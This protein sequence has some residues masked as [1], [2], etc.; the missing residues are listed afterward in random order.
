MV[1]SHTRRVASLCLI[2]VPSC[3]LLL[4]ALGGR[5]GDPWQL[6]D[7]Q[8]RPR[9]RV[10][11]GADGAFEFVFLDAQGAKKL[12][13]GTAGDG[14]PLVK[15]SNGTTSLRIAPE[16]PR[17]ELA[18]TIE[19]PTTK[20]LLTRFG[21][22]VLEG[23]QT[24]R[25]ALNLVEDDM[26]AEIY[27]H[28]RNGGAITLGSNS[29]KSVLVFDKWRAGIEVGE[30]SEIVWVGSRPKSR[31]E[32]PEAEGV[33]LLHVPEVESALTL[34]SGKGSE[35][36]HLHSSPASGCEIRAGS[37]DEGRSVALEVPPEAAKPPSFEA[38]D[39]AGKRVWK[40]P[41]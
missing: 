15:L 4:S 37:G 13:M 5:A 1:T 10:E 23:Q 17:G 21:V 25:V 14:A 36:I 7:A 19:G 39:Q 18:L 9:V 2:L 32:M 20:N 41:E 31:K 33:V 3:L 27:L 12:S 28:G 22:A 6:L 24:P 30:R 35:G 40:L 29:T 8:N 16:G 11:E 38:R 26:R 34:K